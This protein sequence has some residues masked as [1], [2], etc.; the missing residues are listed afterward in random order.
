MRNIWRLFAGD[1]KRIGRN[2]VTVIIVLG[3]V[4]IPSLFSWYNMIACWSVFD[5]TGNLKV[6]VANVDE[7]YKSDLVPIEVNIGDQVVSALRANDQL[8]WVI[9]DED[10]AIDGARSGRYY[11]AVVIPKSFS[12]DMMTFYSDDVE[13]AKITY[14]SNEKKNAIAPKVTDQGADQ[15][16]AQVNQLFAKTLSEAALGISSSLLE[17]ADTADLDGTIGKLSA[18]VTEAGERM[19]K[20]SS[21]LTAYSSV[22]GS[23][24][25]LIGNSSSLLTQVGASADEVSASVDSAKQSAGTVTSAMDDSVS[26]LS[27]ALD[28]SAASYGAVSDS[29]DAAFD[30]AAALSGDSA[31]AASGSGRQR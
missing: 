6:A 10:D 25:S 24:Q 20:G 23:A 28:Q 9:T 31:S 13:H 30:S 5:N 18:H 16:S 4:L 8:R 26:A 17:Y 21:L 1:V 2:V 3:L 19:A 14:Y 12:K 29:V 22:L 11:A 15:V 7:G 27:T